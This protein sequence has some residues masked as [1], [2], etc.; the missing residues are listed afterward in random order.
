MPELPSRRRVITSL[1]LLLLPVPWFD[2]VASDASPPFPVC[3]ELL[4]SSH[5]AI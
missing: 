2:A 4:G 1:T 5:D 3:F